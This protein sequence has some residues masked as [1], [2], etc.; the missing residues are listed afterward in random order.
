MKR[1][2]LTF[3]KALGLS[4]LL[5]LGAGSAQAQTNLGGGKNINFPIT[6]TK[7]GSYKLVNHLNV[8]AGLD[9]IV[10]AEGVDATIDLNSFT[11]T[12]PAVCSKF[13][14]C[15]QGNGTVGIRVQPEQTVRVF[16]GHVRGFTA[17]GVG[18]PSGFNFSQVIARDL[19]VTSNGHGI[20]AYSV[21]VENVLAMENAGVGIYADTGSVLN[22]ISNSNTVGVS[23]SMGSIRG[24]VARA[25]A[26]YGFGFQR[27][28]HQ[29]NI[30]FNNGTP[31]SGGGAFSPGLNNGYND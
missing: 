19:K 6:L 28:T 21:M 13:D 11:I 10:L 12:G 25:N 22:S 4:F 7:S 27:T 18:D 1:T 5:A 8:P 16:N 9:G 29:D 3:A 30:T 24:C 20:R 31:T 2:T 14:N 26:S 17:A 15:F 23:I